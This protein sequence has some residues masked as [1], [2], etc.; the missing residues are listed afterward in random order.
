MV[1]GNRLPTGVTDTIHI[2]MW[3]IQGT[4]NK[5][6]DK[7][8]SN[9]TVKL[10]NSLDIVGLIETHAGVDTCVGIQGYRAYSVNRPRPAGAK[11]DF[12]G[13]AILVK[14]NLLEYVK[15]IKSKV[16]PYEL[17][18]VC[19][20]KGL[21]NTEKDLYIG[22]IYACPEYSTYTTRNSIDI[23]S[24]LEKEVAKYEN[25]GNILLMGDLNARTAIDKD[26][27][28]RENNRFIPGG[29]RYDTVYTCS[30]RRSEDNDKVKHA[31]GY[32]RCLLDLCIAA[33]LRILNGRTL[34]DSCG[35]LT[36]HERQG[37][38]VVVYNS[39]NA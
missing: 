37:S 9:V 15:I 2:G 31:V 16:L 32:G 21:L 24:N 26:Y 25:V 3:N 35:K 4:K 19:V 22:F 6:I 18:W 38:S 28:D 36:C 39:H 29:N 7:L 27:I 14:N 8:D 33:D 23:F 10:I 20:E 1:G 34:G 17:V 12:G 13:I 30:P 5:V 11:R